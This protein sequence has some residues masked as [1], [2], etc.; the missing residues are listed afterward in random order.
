MDH[1]ELVKEVQA[2]NKRL[3]SCGLEGHFR[4]V[5]LGRGFSRLDRW[6]N[7]SGNSN[8]SM[9]SRPFHQGPSL[10]CYA[11]LLGHLAGKLLKASGLHTDDAKALLEDM[12]NVT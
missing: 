1:F 11:A 10:E 7:L 3:E 5:D 6:Y 4:A 12:F 8:D 2:A 9:L